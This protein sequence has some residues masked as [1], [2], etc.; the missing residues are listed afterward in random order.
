MAFNS[1]KD[2]EQSTKRSKLQTLK[3]LLDYLFAYKW[4]I[5]VVLA[6]MGYGVAVRLVNPLIIESAIDDYIGQNDIEG[7]YRLLVAALI[8]NLTLVVTVKLRMYIMAKVCN[9]ILLT[10]R[11]E[12]YTHIQK[13]DFAFFDSRPT[14]KILSRIIGDINSLKD[15]LSNCVTTLVPDGLK[16]IAV[17]V[18]MVCKN[19]ALAFASLLTLPFMAAATFYIE[20]KAHPRWQLFRK[21]SANLN[22]F[23]HEDMAGIRIIQSFHAEKETE[24]TFD[25]LLEEHR[26]AFFDAVRMSDSFGS[27][28]DLSWGLGCIFLYFTG[29]VV[30]GVDAVSVGTFIAFG[31]YLNMF[32][33]PIRNIS[34]FYNQLVTN[35]AGAERIFEILDTEPGIA[36]GAA[37]VEMPEISGEV[38]F[39]HV[40]FSYD[41][42]VKVLDDVSFTIKPGET[43]ALVGP[44]GAGKTTI[45]NLISRFYEVTGG[46]VRIDGRDVREVTLKSLRRQMGIMTQDNFLFSGTIR[47][48]I[49]YGRLDATDE[50]IEA[51]ARAVNAHDFIMKL[52]KGYDTELSERGGGLSVGQKQLLAF[53]RTMV[54][55]PKIL[56]LDE[57]TSSIDTKTELLVQEG[58]EHLL[59]GRT[60]FV[61]AHRLSTI[62]KAD[63]IFVVD[64]GKI[65]EE[66]N[67]EELMEKKGLYYQLYQN[68]IL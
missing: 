5:I 64:D 17:I 19:P 13:L 23:I 31:T 18:I 46:T 11:Q 22:A 59:A 26:N 6:V 47:E 3:R 63:R 48:N 44:T 54:S 38:V 53:A 32:W 55:D 12:L 67:A 28:I 27:V 34:N 20:Y 21:K 40:D 51:A 43:I 65:L 10:I 1:Y 61:I 35:I 49:R 42:K 33:Q 39:D 8:M 16:V 30:L 56:I 50:E 4:Q 14:G 9:R 25:E 58:I 62:R 24:D 68:S 57:A 36:D 2:D 41:D 7:M 52:E 37:A 60:S 15:V 45:V 66:G 29:I